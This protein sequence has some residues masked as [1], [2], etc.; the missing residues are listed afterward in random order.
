MRKEAGLIEALSLLGLARRAGV[1]A[2]GSEATRRALREGR[3]RLVLYAG[4]AS[5]TQLAKIEKLV[6]ARGVRSLR[7]ADRELLGAALGGPPLTAVAVTDEPMAEE[8]ARRLLG[9]A[10]GFKSGRD[11]R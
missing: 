11:W 7:V 3:A 6:G 2:R 4:D 10:A 1:V 5:E 8:L 9:S